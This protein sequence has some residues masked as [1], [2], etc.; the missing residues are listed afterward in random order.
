MKTKKNIKSIAALFLCV[1]LMLT[2]GCAKGTEKEQTAGTT[3]GKALA[4]MNDI[5]ADGII[6]KEQFQSVA[7]KEQKV[8]FKGTTEDGITYVWTYDCA[9]IQNPEDQN[10]KIDFTQENLEEIKK[11]ANDA[12]DALQ[13]TMH[14]KGVICVPT[15]EVTL[16][17]SWESN[18]AY[19]VKEQDGK[20][21][22][23]SDVT[24]TNDKE[25]TTLVMTV[26]S[27]D[28]DCYVIGGVTEEQNKGAD[29]ANQSSKKKDGKEQSQETQ[30]DQKMVQTVRMPM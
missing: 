13:M 2:A 5:P 17:Q 12:N 6:T 30:E 26:T 4:E 19:L 25:S 8:Q 7:G 21:A 9:K 23:M 10:L 16:P 11:Q 28:G 1:I 24:V 18:A 22:K 20:L 29:A 15:L 14:G 27:L 3:S